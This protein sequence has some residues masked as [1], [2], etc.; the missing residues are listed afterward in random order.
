MK[1]LQALNFRRREHRTRIYT[2]TVP[3]GGSAHKECR[4]YATA[5]HPNILGNHIYLTPFRGV[6]V[7]QVSGILCSFA[8]APSP[9]ASGKWQMAT[10]IVFYVFAYARMHPKRQNG[11]GRKWQ[12]VP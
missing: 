6:A 9:M 7:G 4:S 5:R 10:G 12:K 1:L 11:V 3:R 8:A 2:K